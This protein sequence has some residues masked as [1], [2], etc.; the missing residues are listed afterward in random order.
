M[1]GGARGIPALS[2]AFLASTAGCGGA[3]GGG[4]TQPPPPQPD[5]S[6]TL[7]SSSVSLPQ[8]GTSS[9]LTVSVT[10]ENGF[11]G[12]VQVTL[13]SLPAGITSNPTSP[14]SVASGGNTAVVFGAASTASTAIFRYCA[15]HQRLPLAFL[16]SFAQHPGGFH[17]KP[18]AQQ[19]C[20]KRLRHPAGSSRGR[21]ASPPCRL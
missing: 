11:S 15:R 8:G 20:S 21:A 17:A 2:L 19:L 16:G 18:S 14:F 5:F 3:G 12:T 1:W 10:A 4:G 6:I 13:N 7:S 9:P